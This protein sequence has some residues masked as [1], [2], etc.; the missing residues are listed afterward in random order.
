ML[1]VALAGTMSVLVELLDRLQLRVFCLKDLNEEFSHLVSVHESILLPTI[2]HRSYLGSQILHA[3]H[4]VFRQLKVSASCE[5]FELLHEHSHVV[6]TQ[7]DEEWW[8]WYSSSSPSP[9]I[10]IVTV[11]VAM[12]FVPDVVVVVVGRIEIEFLCLGLLCSQIL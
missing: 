4:V 3:M 10:S 9:S 7:T 12:V 11:F 2:R 5:H 1:P 8:R 6:A